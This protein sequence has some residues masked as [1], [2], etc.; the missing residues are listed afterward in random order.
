[1]KQLYVWLAI[2]CG[3]C[4]PPEAIAGPIVVDAGWYTFCFEGPGSPATDCG[5]GPSTGNP[6]TFTAVGPVLL[7]VTDAF[8]V[9]DVFDVYVNSV[10]A[11]TTSSPGPGPYSMVFWTDN[12][13]EAFASPL[14]SSGSLWLNPGSYSVDIFASASP[15]GSGEAFIE[16]VSAA[17][18][19]EPVSTVLVGSGLAVAWLLRR[20]IS[21]QHK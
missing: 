6:F 2:A 21:R 20:R 18:I 14:W 5:Y 10:L 1:V 9:G 8:R 7:K 16:V 19:P 12:P 13:D 4:L 11:F 17:A 15:W 3:L